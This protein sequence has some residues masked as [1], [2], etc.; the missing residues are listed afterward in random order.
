MK[1]TNHLLVLAGIC[2]CA[3]TS[4]KTPVFD[5][6][7][8]WQFSCDDGRSATVDLPHDAMLGA[9][10]SADAPGSGGEAYFQGGTYTYTKDFEVPAEW[11]RVRVRIPSVLRMP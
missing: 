1:I 4:T 7:S 10:R 6:N 2:V 5:I 3:C 11:L 8:G 9:K